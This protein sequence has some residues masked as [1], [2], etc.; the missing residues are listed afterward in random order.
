MTYR[1]LTKVMTIDLA[2]GSETE[3]IKELP[4]EIEG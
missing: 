4:P 3:R 2:Y 1:G